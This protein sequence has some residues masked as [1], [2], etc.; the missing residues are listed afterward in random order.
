MRSFAKITNSRQIL[1]PGN[2]KAISGLRTPHSR[3][4]SEMAFFLSV[5]DYSQTKVISPALIRSWWVM[6]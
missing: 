5:K 4:A 6:R 2:R 1:K 3:N